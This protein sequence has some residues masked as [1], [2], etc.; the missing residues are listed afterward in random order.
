MKP[1]LLDL[2]CGAGGCAMGY[3]RAGFEVVGV[4]IKPQKNYPFRMVVADALW[5]PF[6]LQEFDVIHASPPCQHYSC[7]RHLPGAVQYPDLVAPIRRVLQTS[8]KP[9][10]I[11]NVPGS[12][13]INP[14]TL[15]GSVLCK[16]LPDGAKLRR[17]RLF[18]SSMPIRGTD[19]NHKGQTLGVYGDIRRSRRSGMLRGTKAS[20]A[21]AQ[22]LFDVQ[23]MTPEE[24]TESIPPAYTE[25][26]G[27]QLM[28]H[29]FPAKAPHE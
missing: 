13:L 29:I 19:H 2:F 8:G 26:I 4:D 18:E 12:P 7:L 14:I 25:F 27:K 21:E 10:I 5:P 17:H 24:L 15:C 16:T 11:E 23:W 20:W 1:R 22:E 9:Y 6:D 3:H 28:A